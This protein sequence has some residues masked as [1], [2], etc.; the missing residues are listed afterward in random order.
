[1]R[2][3]YFRV[4]HAQPGLRG[5]VSGTPRE[6]PRAR[7][8]LRRLR[9]AAEHLPDAAA[10]R[11]RLIGGRYIAIGWKVVGGLECFGG[12]VAVVFCPSAASS[13]LVDLL[14]EKGGKR[15]VGRKRLAG[16]IHERLF[17]YLF[18]NLRS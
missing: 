12:R 5:R 1:M 3:A 6:R 9:R 17:I 10:F 8:P 13:G 2:G 7:D 11:E 14:M 4:L 15:G 16:F 18:G